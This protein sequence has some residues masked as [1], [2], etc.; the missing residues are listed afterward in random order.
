MRSQTSERI[1]KAIPM[2]QTDVIQV[3]YIPDNPEDVIRQHTDM[4]YRIAFTYC[5]NR[6]DAEDITQE[7]FYRYLRKTPRLT[8]EDHL[9]AWLIRVAVNASKSLL[10]TAWLRK[11]VPI[12]EQEPLPASESTPVDLYHAVMSLPEKY[13]SVVILYYYDGFTVGEIAKVL[14][15]TE[16]AV[17]TQL[18]RARA[19]LK[20][21]LMED[22]QN[23]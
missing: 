15:R 4:V 3:E 1:R 9:K 7:V 6:S 2:A 22:W 16:T 19:M 23:E 17:Q 10:R 20:E 21:E 12:S 8:G 11:T 18:H 5:R 14:H 13:R